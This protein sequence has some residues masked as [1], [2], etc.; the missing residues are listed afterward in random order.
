MLIAQK[1]YIWMAGL[2]IALAISVLPAYSQQIL[3]PQTGF[4]VSTLA[5]LNAGVYQGSAT[6]A[7]LKQ[8]GD[9]GLGTFE[10]LD[11]EMVAIDGSVYQVKA[12]GVADAVADNVKTPFYTVTSFRKDRSLPLTGQITYQAMQQQIDTQLPSLNLPY[13]IR[14]QGTFPELKVRSIPKQIPPYR[15][16][17]DVLKQQQRIFDLQ[18]VRGTL[19]GFRLPQYLNGVNVGGYHFHFLTR[20]RR[21][22][23]HVIDGKFLDPIADL[24]SLHD[25]KIVLPDNAAF[26]QASLEQSPKK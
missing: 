23:G 21:A 19:V 22:G 7:Q 17:N 10:G 13:A 15:P 3:Q 16:L 8:H 4:Q 6:V 9:F 2:F 1:Q 24:D 25:W 20:D 14:I 12:D 18:N 26:A 5:A 11:G